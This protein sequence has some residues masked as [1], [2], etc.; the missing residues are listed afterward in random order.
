VLALVAGGVQEEPVPCPRCAA[1]VTIEQS[2]RTALGYRPFRCPACRRV[3]N[4][5]TGTPCNHLQYPTDLVLLVVLWRRRY[6]LS[7]RD[8]AEMFLERGFVFS[9]EAVRAWEARFAPLLTARLRAK[10]RGQHRTKWHADETSLRVDGRWCSLYRA[11]DREG[12]L[13]DVLLS[14]R[15]DMAAARRFFR[16]ALAIAEQ[17]PEQIT[18]DGH[19]ADPRAIREAL[20]NVVTHRTSRYKNNRIEQDHRGIKQRYYPLRGFGSFTSAVRFCTAFEE[21]R[22]Y[23]RAQS[24]SAERISLADRRQRFQD[25]WAAVMA[26]MAAACPAAVGFHA[27]RNTRQQ[28]PSSH[29]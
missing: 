25:R 4:E 9:H 21:Q 16:Q 14:E 6:K 10:R 3:C 2:R 20:G 17:T 7:L 29:F 1:S 23:S 26:E 11:I 8:L 18:T 15:R 5:R 19:D 28:R 12:N 24:R 22:Q 27:A 13:V